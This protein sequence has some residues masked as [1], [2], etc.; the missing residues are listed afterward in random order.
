VEALNSDQVLENYA[1]QYIESQLPRPTEPAP[2]AEDE[3]RPPTP[4]DED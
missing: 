4:E 2:S 3:D 1:L